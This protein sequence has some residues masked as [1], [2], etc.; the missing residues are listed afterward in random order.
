[1]PVLLVALGMLGLA[2]G[3]FLNVVAHRLPNGLSVV[4]PPSHCPRC[5]HPIRVRHNVPVLGWVMLRGKCHDCGSRISPRYPAV[6]L[7]VGLWYPITALV[8]A[9][10]HALAALPGILLSGTTAI[11]L[12]LLVGPATRA[13]RATSRPNRQ[14]PATLYKECR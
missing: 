8:L 9:S 7:L 1:M 14:Y 11:A 5:M 12:A 13:P 3:S 4:S 2:V 10:H 6:E